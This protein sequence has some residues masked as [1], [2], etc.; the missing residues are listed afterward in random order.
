MEYATKKISLLRIAGISDQDTIVNAVHTGFQATP[1]L[2]VALQPFVLERRNTVAVYKAQLALIQGPLQKIHDKARSQTATRLNRRFQPTN[3]RTE[4]KPQ[5]AVSSASEQPSAYRKEASM[6]PYVPVVPPGPTRSRRSADRA[7]ERVRKCRF[8]PDPECGDGEH[9]DR[10]CKLYGRAL[11]TKVT[12][13][14]YIRAEVIDSEGTD[15]TE[16]GL[17]IKELDEVEESV[18]RY[19]RAQAAHFCEVYFATQPGFHALIRTPK[20]GSKGGAPSHTCNLCGEVFSSGNT[21]HRHLR[22]VEH[23]RAVGQSPTVVESKARLGMDPTAGLRDYHHVKL[24]FATDIAG[25]THLA[26]MD[27]GYGNL[28]VDE[29]FLQAHGADAARITLPQPEWVL[30]MGGG[31]KL[32]DEV[33][34]LTIYLRGK[35]GS[36]ATFTRPF[37]VFEDLSVPLL[38]GIDI[39]AP[40]DM[41]LTF[42]PKPMVTIGPCGG[43][44]VPVTMK[45]EQ[46]YRKILVRVRSAIKLPPRRTMKVDVTLSQKLSSGET[47]IFSPSALH[48]ASTSGIGA[49]HAMVSHDQNQIAFTNFLDTTVQLFRGTVIG[50]MQPMGSAHYVAWEEAQKEVL[51]MFGEKSPFLAQEPSS[52]QPVGRPVFDP[53]AISSTDL[54]PTESQAREDAEF[55]HRARMVPGK[56][57]VPT[58]HQA[59]KPCREEEWE[60]PSWIQEE[61]KPVYAYSLPP[62]IKTPSTEMSTW[63][64]VNVND[65]DDVSPEQ[66]C[67]MKLFLRRHKAIFNDEMGCV[68]ESPDDWLRILVDPTL[69]LKVKPKPAYKMNP[70]GRAAIDKQFDENI[71]AGRMERVDKPS[72]Y[73]IQVFVVYAANG[74]ERP[75]LDMR[76]LNA[77][78]PH[79]GYPLPDQSRITESIG[80]KRWLATADIT[81]AF[82]QWLLH[83]DDRYRAA[84]ISHTG[85]EQFAVT[86]MG[87]KRSVQHQQKLMDKA[88]AGLTWRVVSVY[89]DDICIYADTFAEFFQACEE[90]FTILSNLGITLKAK[91]CFLGF[92]SLELLGYLVD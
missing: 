44:Q 78:V 21:L 15:G 47:Y 28:A 54:P 9:W 1:T 6:I 27:I 63:E 7:A 34:M 18:D 52:N 13:S 85:H 39:I 82:Y 32:L 19:D 17:A 79:D 91:K 26:C 5:A 36:T 37:H 83:P 31:K 53:D 25:A 8:Y 88:F 12:R 45:Q 20:S 61:Y 50:T 74:K 14:Y 65:K 24:P 2:T 89:V 77:L 51:A 49:P 66:L 87:Y 73:T 67:A 90:V 64:E 60:F 29:A 56:S 76:E 43:I 16:E 3:S 68:R 4:Y 86:M 92:H 81:S 30:G 80:G 11:S 41:V 35:D 72:P 22:E 40:E 84:V 10:E 38:V 71:R 75:V 23:T 57:P 46:Q 33:A 59:E 55:L 69:E 70:K 48:S 58:T 62:G 42:K